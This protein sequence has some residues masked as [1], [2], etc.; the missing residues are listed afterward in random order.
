MDKKPLSRYFLDPLWNDNQILVA[1][2]GICSALAVTIKMEVALTMALAVSFVTAFSSFF[3]SLSSGINLFVSIF[4]IKDSVSKTFKA[5]SLRV[6]FIF[7][8]AREIF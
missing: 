1:V 3:V 7:C 2:L 4:F 5:N 6:R 8:L